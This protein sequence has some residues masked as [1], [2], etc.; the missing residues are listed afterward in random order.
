MIKNYCYYADKET[1]LTRSIKSVNFFFWETYLGRQVWKD[2]KPILQYLLNFHKMIKTMPFL[3]NPSSI[4][5]QMAQN[6]IQMGGL[7]LHSN[8]FSFEIIKDWFWQ[9]FLVG[10][11]GYPAK[12]LFSGQI[13]EF[14]TICICIQPEKFLLSV[15]VSGQQNAN[16]SKKNNF[17]T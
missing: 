16:I 10:M 15:S 1:I 7:T 14:F 4:H 2:Q 12:Y 13:V 3:L 9:H 17:F 11:H 8:E 6:V 5:Y